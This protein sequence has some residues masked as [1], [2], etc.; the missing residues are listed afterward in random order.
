MGTQSLRIPGR[1][2]YLGM[3]REGDPPLRGT[4]PHR[5]VPTPTYLGKT[6]MHSDE[7]GHGRAADD[8]GGWSCRSSS[9]PPQDPRPLLQSLPPQ[10]LPL[11]SSSPA[12]AVA[13]L[14]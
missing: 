3:Q 14:G 10:S 4:P 2:E 1:E 7:V 9:H 11:T 8:P 12:D 13:A 5:P 6:G